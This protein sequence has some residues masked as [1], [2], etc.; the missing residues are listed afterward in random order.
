MA[1]KASKLR[2]ILTEDRCHMVPC[3]W[4]A[5]SAK[6]IGDAGF[7]FTFMSGF[8]VSAA[9]LGLPDA[10]LISYA[11]MAGQVRDICAA[12]PIPVIGDG[13]TGYGNAL[14]VE[15]TVRGYAQAG[16]A[17]VMIE[18][19]LAPK[20]CGHTKGKLVVDRAEA[21]DRIR[22]A[23]HARDEV[24]RAGGDILILARTDARGVIGLDE[25]IWRANA[26]RDAGADILFVE[27]PQ[28]ESEMARVTKEAPGIHMA[29]MVEGGKTPIPPMVRLRELGFGLAIFPLTLF[30]ASMR[31]IEA[32]LAAM[33]TE[34]HP[35]DLL[36]SF[37]DLK[38]TVGFDAYYEAE[39]R[40]AGARKDAAE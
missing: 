19:Q 6:M 17:C 36:M 11:E 26:F 13:D 18:D 32:G 22:A 5:L 20:R 9:R 39:T 37:D 33:K 35:A 21:I 14:N 30:S 24:R 25:A 15:R 16:A 10:G 27:A 8:A 7:P 31:A 23:A 38:R 28:S 12:T 2:A 34:R 4:D 29:N 40:Y 3:C 1:A